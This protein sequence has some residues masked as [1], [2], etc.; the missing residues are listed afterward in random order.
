[1]LENLLVDCH[2]NVIATDFGF[3]N[4]FEHRTDDGTQ[5]SCG[6]PSYAAPKLVIAEGLYSTSVLPLTSGPMVSSCMPYSP[7]ISP[8]T[9]IQP[10][11]TV[12]T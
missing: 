8:L 4:H 9:T 7:T 6:S 5:K 2:Q 1:M 12:A 3:A 11:Q 10:I